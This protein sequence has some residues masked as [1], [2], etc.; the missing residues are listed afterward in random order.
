MEFRYMGF[1][2]KGSARI[3][4][5]DCLTKGADAQHFTVSAEMGLFL[6]HRVAIQEGPS[7]CA[8]K[9]AADLEKT[10]DAPHELTSEDLSAHA[11]AITEAAARKAESRKSAPKRTPDMSAIEASPWRGPRTF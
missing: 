4:R 11:L 5:F 8:I 2:Q 10:A 3:Y 7:L 9:L 6:T 1:D